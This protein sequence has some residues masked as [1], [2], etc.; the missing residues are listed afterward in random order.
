MIN[1]MKKWSFI[2]LFILIN[3]SICSCFAFQ[4]IINR[5]DNAI[6]VI[7]DTIEDISEKVKEFLR[8]D[9]TDEERYYV[10]RST[11]AYLLGKYDLVEN[12]KLLYY[13]NQVGSVVAMASDKSITFKGYR[14]LVLD[15]ELPNAYGTPGG[16]VFISVG[17]LRLCENEDELAAVFAHEVKHIVLDHPMKAVS[18]AHRQEALINIAKRAAE[19]VANAI[20]ISPDFFDGVLKGFGNVLNDIITVFNNGYSK[21]TEY[22]A[23]KGAIKILHTAGYSVN[24]L[25]S[26][27]SK[28]PQNETSKYGSNH[29]TSKDRIKAIDKEIKKLKITPNQI[30]Q[31]RTDRFRSIMRETGISF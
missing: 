24:A 10:G 1:K 13:I 14:F 29:P 25:K 18:K 20:D 28:L 11:C 5:T 23:D 21:D 7:K 12:E 17:M 30:L 6:G 27:I 9:F 16:L 2:I 4:T 26:I 8:N 31:E 3:L 15:D 19:E 22:E